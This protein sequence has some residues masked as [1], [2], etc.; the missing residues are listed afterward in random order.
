MFYHDDTYDEILNLK[1]YLLKKK[2]NKLLDSVDLWIQMV[3]TNRLTGQFP[4]FF[5]S[6]Y[7]T[8]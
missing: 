5:F 7:I 3:A 2:K 4:R 1:N 6:L 8:T